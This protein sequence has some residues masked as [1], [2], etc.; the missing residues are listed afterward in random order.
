MYAHT[1]KTFNTYICLAFP[2]YDFFHYELLN[3]LGCTGTHQSSLCLLPNVPTTSN[4]LADQ[5]SNQTEC[6]SSRGFMFCFHEFRVF[7]FYTCRFGSLV[8]NFF[9]LW[10]SVFLCV[11]PNNLVLMKELECATFLKFINTFPNV[12]FWRKLW[13]VFYRETSFVYIFSHSFSSL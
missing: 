13:L 9:F 11:L 1:K 3:Q 10:S 4:L 7:V 2:V 6:F 12:A 5:K 8:Y